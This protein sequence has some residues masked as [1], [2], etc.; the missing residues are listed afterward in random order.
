MMWFIDIAARPALPER[1][2]FNGSAKQ[3]LLLPWLRDLCHAT[4]D[5]LRHNRT[6]NTSGVMVAN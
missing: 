2:L 6:C 4:D 1:R 5:T 3:R